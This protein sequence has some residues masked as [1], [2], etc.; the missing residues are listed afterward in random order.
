MP[1]SP[2]FT[3]NVLRTE[4]FAGVPIMV[5]IAMILVL[6]DQNLT[7]QPVVTVR[8][9]KYH[10]VTSMISLNNPQIALHL[11]T[12]EMRSPTTSDYFHQ[13]KYPNSPDNTKA[14]IIDHQNF[15]SN[16]L[17]EIWIYDI[18]EKQGKPI[19]AFDPAVEDFV[20]AEWSPDNEYVILVIEKINQT[21]LQ[22]T[23]AVIH[24]LTNSVIFENDY[25]YID[26][27]SWAPVS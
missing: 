19:Y 3:M 1:K 10:Y 14:I 21:Q 4:L 18:E 16:S 13:L 2:E 24:V 20:Q 5:L 7:Y 6:R 22:D 15:D 11:A 8:N 23:I 9:E 27:V 12:M 26:G 25:P 17:S